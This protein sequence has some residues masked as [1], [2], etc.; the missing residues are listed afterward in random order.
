MIG[1]FF[2]DEI[3]DDFQG[4]RALLFEHV[5]F[6]LQMRFVEHQ[7]RA[8][9]GL[10]RHVETHTDIIVAKKAS[11]NTIPQIRCII[12]QRFVYHIPSIDRVL[13]ASDNLFYM[14]VHRR[15][16]GLCVGDIRHPARD[17]IPDQRMAINPHVVFAR[18]CNYTVG[19]AEA[20]TRS[21]FRRT[22]LQF[23]SRRY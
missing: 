11:E 21:L 6:F 20:N 14:T 19:A 3:L 17:A 5:G 7:R 4:A 23:V 13:I 18:K 8:G 1:V 2:G 10:V 16:N 22:P 12:L 9:I 15:L